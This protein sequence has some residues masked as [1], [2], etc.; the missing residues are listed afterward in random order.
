MA[1]QK[2]CYIISPIGDPDSKERK[3]ADFVRNHIVKRVVTSCGYQVPVRADDPDKDLIL[4]DIIE[5][6]FEADLVIAD[7]T[8]FN[9]NVFYELGI[10]H[11]AQKPAIHLIQTGQYPTFDLGGN[12]VIFIDRDYEKVVKAQEEIETRI[13]AIEADPK[14]FYS[15]VQQHIQFKQLDLFKKT[16]MGTDGFLIDAVKSIIRS[17]QN[18]KEVLDEVHQELVIKKQH[19]ST[20]MNLS[21]LFQNPHEQRLSLADMIK[22]NSGDIQNL[23]HK[24][25]EIIQKN[26]QKQ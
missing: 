22:Q 20:Y 9:P 17:L 10:R 16:K 11:T 24:N 19:H 13:K 12:K 3:W 15:Q 1:N 26:E 14:Q 8:S 4:A 21:D 6:M 18:Q 7:L 2:T 23:L 25:E 5:Q